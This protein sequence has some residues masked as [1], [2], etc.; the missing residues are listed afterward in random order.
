M[1]E[2]VLFEPSVSNTVNLNSLAT[3]ML[4]LQER[5]ILEIC[6]IAANFVDL[7]RELGDDE[8]SLCEIFSL[9][10]GG[11]L[12]PSHSPDDDSVMPSNLPRINS[13]LKL[14]SAS[15]RAVFASFVRERLLQAGIGI[16]ENDFLSTAK[17]EHTFV[18]VKNAFSDEAYDVFSQEFSNPRVSY[19][20][21]FK[22]ALAAVSDGR[23]SYCLLPIEE[24][25][26]RISTVD[27][28]IFKSDLKVVSIT[29]V[30]G[31]DGLADM[32]YALVSR[33]FVESAIAADDDR[34][35]EFRLP[36]DFSERL[37]DILSAAESFRFEIYRL[38]T[39]RFDTDDGERDYFS[40]VLRSS[41]TD[42]VEMLIYLTLFADEF[43]AVGLYKNIE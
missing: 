2:D 4:V 31:F 12:L 10:S 23:V 22:D 27:E 36:K 34:Y 19:L 15:D 35:F 13:Y 11:E 16:S 26:A 39:V 30:W 5:R 8:M 3:D 32:K 38:N 24:R 14:L 25:G 43:N 7:V 6:E 33:H 17:S 20:N 42:F 41:G 29:P 1:V 37:G 18:Y 21:S 28:M 9:L 40:I